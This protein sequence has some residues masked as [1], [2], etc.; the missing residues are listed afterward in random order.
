[1]TGLLAASVQAE[2]TVADAGSPGIL[3]F[4]ATFVLALAVIGLM[5]SLT[6]H[7]R[8]V[9]ASPEPPEPD[10]G[11]LD[12]GTLDDGTAGDAGPGA[13]PADAT[14]DDAGPDDRARRA[15]ERGAPD[16]PGGPS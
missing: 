16:V 7:L 2:T 9:A 14:V 5:L 3:G 10:D 12:D 8:R 4:V 6:R 15:P 1:V 11:T 13:A